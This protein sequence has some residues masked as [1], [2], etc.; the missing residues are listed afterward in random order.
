MA[1]PAELVLGGE[2]ASGSFPY[3]TLRSILDRDAFGFAG[4]GE[5]QRHWQHYAV[6]C[7]TPGTDDDGDGGVFCDVADSNIPF[8]CRD[9][10]DVQSLL[11]PPGAGR[12]RSPSPSSRSTSTTTGSPAA[13]TCRLT[14]TSPWST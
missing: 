11:D 14:S 4:T 13:R 12:R 1:S 5:A 9:L 10:R 6:L 7:R 2:E 3:G 8:L